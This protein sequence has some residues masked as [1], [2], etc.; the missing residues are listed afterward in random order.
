MATDVGIAQAVP[1]EGQRR[2]ASPAI[3]ALSCTQNVLRSDSRLSAARE[4]RLAAEESVRRVYH[5]ASLP[6]PNI[7]WCDSPMELSETWSRGVCQQGVGEN[8]RHIL[9][10]RSYRDSLRYLVTNRH[11]RS[12]PSRRT[13]PIRDRLR[14]V[15]AGVEAAVLEV[16]GDTRPSL[17]EWI[18]NSKRRVRT[19]RRPTLA[20]SG[21]GPYALY[22]TSVA[23]RARKSIYGDT[24]LALRALGSI[25]ERVEW[26]V[27][28]E[29][30]CWL[31]EQPDALCADGQGRLH[32]ASGPA[33]RY[34]DGFALFA[35]KGVV[36]PSWTITHP[37]QISLRW[38]DAEIDPTIRH[39]MIDIFT[40]K[41]FIEA[42][43]ADAVARDGIGTLWRRK[44]T[45]RG[46]TIDAWAAIEYA[47][48]TMPGHRIF[49]TVPADL[50]A[51]SD[52]FVQL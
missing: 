44:W 30:A 7:I 24:H 4:H 14:V 11:S 40:P 34:R 21:Y 9:F 26:I 6:R 37:E 17:F 48:P 15:S 5:A 38:I 29:G 1:A 43:G 32:C 19:G 41:R 3:T 39:A 52:A 27:P 35:Y 18:K 13:L 16:V 51:P 8:V 20:G 22:R 10:D 25:A 46:T 12:M 2:R 49:E 47:S 50:R 23:V 42:G 31:G 28:H 45:H 33:L 36:V